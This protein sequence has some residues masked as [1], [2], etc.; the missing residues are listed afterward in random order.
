MFKLYHRLTSGRSAIWICLLLVVVAVSH[1]EYTYWTAP[2]PS[3]RL[4]TAIRAAN[5][6]AILAAQQIDAA[7]RANHDLRMTLNKL[8]DRLQ[9]VE[10]AHEKMRI[11]F[12]K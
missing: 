10:K 9:T 12:S 1:L 11:G 5:E 4:E 7:H 8:Q 3:P 6:D 2:N